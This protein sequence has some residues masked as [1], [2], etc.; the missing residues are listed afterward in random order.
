MLTLRER[1]KI[2]ARSTGSAHDHSLGR[3]G[4]REGGRVEQVRSLI[5]LSYGC[6]TVRNTHRGCKMGRAVTLTLAQ[7]IWDYGPC[8][9]ERMVHVADKRVTKAHL[10]TKSGKSPSVEYIRTLT[11]APRFTTGLGQVGPHI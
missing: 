7:G 9:N 2:F 8:M 11:A 5:Y 6:C 4:V 1:P 10:N 3:S